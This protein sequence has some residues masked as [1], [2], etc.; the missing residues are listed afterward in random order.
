[1]GGLIVRNMMYQVQN[2]AALHTGNIFP[3]S[4][5]NILDVVTLKSP[6]NGVVG[7]VFKDWLSGCSNCRQVQE[8]AERQ[9]FYER[10][11]KW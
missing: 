3:P 8:L 2:R 9:H 1:M 11:A 7:S 5:G 6:H 4:L 10:D